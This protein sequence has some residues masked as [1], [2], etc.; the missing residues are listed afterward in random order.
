MLGKFRV[1]LSSDFHVNVY[2][3]RKEVVDDLLNEEAEVS[4]VVPYGEKLNYFIKKGCKLYDINLDR[5]NLGILDNIILLRQYYKVIKKDNPDIVLLYGTKSMLYPGIICRLMG[6]K[7]IVNINGLGTV[8]S[9]GDI[10]KNIILTLYKYVVPKASCTFFQNKYNFNKLK[11]LK[12]LSKNSCLIPGS[13]VNIKKYKL[14]DFPKEERIVFLFCARLI[15]EKGLFQFLDAAKILK[16]ECANVDFNI[17]GM[18]DASM[19]AKVE[20]YNAFVNYYG[21]QSD[22]KDF[23][24]NAQC[25]VLP[26]YYGEG[27]SNSLLESAASG[28][29][30]ITTNMPGCRETVINNETGYIINPQSTNELVYAMKKFINLTNNERITMGLK[31]RKYVEKHF[32]RKIVQEAYIREIKKALSLEGKNA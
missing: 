5:S 1:L 24:K 19:V 27:I 11:E 20:E 14:L 3:W 2:S 23:I 17:I 15:P 22:V 7:Y 28:R 8:E 21:F 30:I 31:A 12:I 6:I 9:L 29:A 25:I 32:N 13:G 4:L 10:V 16:E 18:G 26:S